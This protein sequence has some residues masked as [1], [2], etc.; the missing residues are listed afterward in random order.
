M[1]GF[2]SVT[3]CN[4]ILGL[5]FHKAAHIDNTLKSIDVRYKLGISF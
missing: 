3:R 1:M 5:G 2:H 4:R